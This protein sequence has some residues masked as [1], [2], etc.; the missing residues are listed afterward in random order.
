MGMF[1]AG[2]LSRSIAGIQSPPAAQPPSLS[3]IVAGAEK[4]FRNTTAILIV[5]ICDKDLRLDK[6]LFSSTS[7]D[8]Q[9]GRFVIS[10]V[11]RTAFGTASDYVCLTDTNPNY[12]L[13]TEIATILTLIGLEVS[14]F[15]TSSLEGDVI[16]KIEIFNPLEPPPYIFVLQPKHYEGVFGVSP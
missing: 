16:A 4:L 3:D 11:H 1:G 12:R 6:F 15:A 10:A 2:E 8:A 7:P 5:P 13:L 14:F 9:G